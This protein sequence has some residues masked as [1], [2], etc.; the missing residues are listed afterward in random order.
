VGHPPTTTAMM[1]RHARRAVIH[2]RREPLTDEAAAARFE[3]MQAQLSK[4]GAE[5]HRIM[6]ELFLCD[7]I[8]A[9][10]LLKERSGEEGIEYELARLVKDM[11]SHSDQAAAV[12]ILTRITD[13]ELFVHTAC[14]LARSLIIHQPYRLFEGDK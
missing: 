13:T 6:A 9:L 8:R 11:G 2:K 14:N 10:K 12:S 7:N 3:T 5:P 1:A 4:P